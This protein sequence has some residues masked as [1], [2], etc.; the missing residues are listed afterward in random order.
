MLF[1]VKM[2]AKI[3]VGNIAHGVTNDVVI[4][5]FERYGVVTECDVL[6]SFGFVVSLFPLL[7]ALVFLI[8]YCCY[9]VIHFFIICYCSCTHSVH[10]KKY[11]L[12]TVKIKPNIRNYDS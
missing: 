3:F 12:K 1:V 7:F 10:L 6:G 4:P 5:M 8:A 9:V 2:P 11:I